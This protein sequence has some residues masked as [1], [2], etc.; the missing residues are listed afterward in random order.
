[1]AENE[2]RPPVPHIYPQG[3]VFDKIEDIAGKT[4]VVMGL[5]LNG[6]GEASV[7]FLLKHGANVIATD[8]KSA[9]DLAPTIASL[10]ND[11][12]LDTSKLTYRLGEHRIEDFENADCVIKNPGVKYDGNKY[13]AA[14]KAI[15]TDISLFLHFSKAPIIAVTGSKGKSSTVSAI[16]YGLKQSGFNAYLG[17]NI[18][19]SPLTFLENTDSTTPVVLELSSWQL[20]DLNGRKALKP[21]ISI[22]TKIIPDHQNFY[23]S[24]LAYVND[25]KLIYADQTKKD[26]A[27]FD[28]DSDPAADGGTLIDNWG[29]IFAKECSHS[30]GPTVLRYSKKQLPEGV[31]GVWQDKKGNGIA[32]LSTKILDTLPQ[33]Y[34]KNT[35]TILKDLIVPGKH[36]RLNCLN[37]ALVLRIMGVSPERI[38]EVLGRWSGIEHR[39]E[40]F[41]EKQIAGTTYRFYNDSAA[42]VPEAS[43]EATQAFGKPVIFLTGGTDKG[44][45]LSPVA[46]G[47]CDNG[48]NIVPKSV[49]LLAGTATDKLIPDFNAE[50]ISYNGPFDSLDAML[51]QLKT[52][53]ESSPKEKNVQII[54]FSPGATSFGM[55]KNEFDRG[56][57][58]KEKVKKIFN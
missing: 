33:D 13:L 16:Y 20:A 29:D 50:K 56:N 27:I 28:F 32:R 9:E 31:L 18:T 3:C 23:H 17:G 42:T 25:K 38:A 48:K 54:V 55:F 5:G 22:I 47:I 45:D 7:R 46:R 24:M 1:M 26:Y 40:F 4:V 12:E 51:L 14:A 11:P 52:N 21:H 41:H 43:A 8:M 53:L 30:G 6:G 2:P 37:A 36:M 39:L 35:E 10:D 19:V 15:E 34:E 49:Y 44:L 58:F 57:Q